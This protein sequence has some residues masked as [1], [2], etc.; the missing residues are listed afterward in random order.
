[1]A[2]VLSSMAA[3]WELNLSAAARVTGK[4]KDFR[5]LIHGQ[6]MVFWPGYEA[7]KQGVYVPGEEKFECGDGLLRVARLTRLLSNRPE[8]NEP[9]SPWD[10]GNANGVPLCSWNM[11]YAAVTPFPPLCRF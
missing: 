7:E 10:R 3:G 5:G 2:L 9:T 8:S 1:M 4:D 6:K 11:K